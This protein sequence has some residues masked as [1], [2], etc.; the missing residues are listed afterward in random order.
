MA[1]LAHGIALCTFAAAL[2]AASPLAG[3]T[4]RDMAGRTVSLPDTLRRILPYDNKTNALLFPLAADIMPARAR[5]MRASYFEL[6]SPAWSRLKEVDM[7]QAEEVMRLRPDA[8]IVAAF[9]D[10]RTSLENYAAF[11]Q[12]VN[13]PLVVVDIDLMHFDRAIDFLGALLG[14]R[15][16]AGELAAFVRDIYKDVEDVRRR[17]APHPPRAYM[18]ND[19]NGLRT[20]P[21][22]SRHAQLFDILGVENVVAAPAAANGFAYVSIEQLLVW[23]PEYVLCVGKGEVNPY[24]T[25][26]KSSLW[27]SLPAVRT[28]KVR[29]VPEDPYS[30]FD[31]PP[32]VNRLAG[33]IWFMELFGGQPPE[34]TERRIR[35]FYRLFYGYTLSDREYRR[36]FEWR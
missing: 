35:E 22:G 23:Q 1:R 7:R 14:R 8:L 32:S 25:A 24:R 27:R 5:W 15:E 34:V 12:R 21:R 18:A 28:G 3:R 31:I 30:W 33:L 20:A 2:A 17:N 26:L 19:A 29:Y 6:I 4:V 9:L 10:D 13:V 11:A 16:R 36:L